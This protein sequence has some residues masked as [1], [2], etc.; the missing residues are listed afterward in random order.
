MPPSLQPFLPI[1]LFAGAA[2]FLLAILLRSVREGMDTLPKG[3]T[4]DDEDL[5]ATGL[6]EGV[7][8]ILREEVGEPAIFEG[9]GGRT[10]LAVFPDGAHVY[11]CLARVRDRL[12]GRAIAFMPDD[13]TAGGVPATI[14][15]LNERDSLDALD[16]MGTLG[17]KDLV[18][19]LRA[20]R[21]RFPLEVAGCGE[22]WVEIWFRKPPED[23]GFY[24]EA[25]AL[26]PAAA[27]ESGGAGGFR[28]R[29]ERE[30]LLYLFW[31]EEEAAAA[32][33]G[34]RTDG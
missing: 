19:R 20:W 14:V 28:T 33:R 5:K 3:D 23:E 25:A 6:G 27:A 30:G 26:A 21:S 34:G 2:V 4:L 24:A 12:A 22:D 10:G 16:F 1:V 9:T 31:E 18:P 11:P 29:V 8:A 13:N 7:P 17:R 15:V 32:R